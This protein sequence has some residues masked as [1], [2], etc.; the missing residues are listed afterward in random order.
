MGAAAQLV[1]DGGEVVPPHSPIALAYLQNKS[2]L[3]YIEYPNHETK[4]ELYNDLNNVLLFKS[5][6]VESI[7]LAPFQ[8]V[9][10]S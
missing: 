3:N 8:N 4:H 6:S 5:R 9:Y 10:Q 7:V 1:G 2:I